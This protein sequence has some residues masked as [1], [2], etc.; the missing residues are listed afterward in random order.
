MNNTQDKLHPFS[1]TISDGYGAFQYEVGLPS[2]VA[3][4]DVV[5]AIGKKF[6]VEVPE[7]GKYVPVKD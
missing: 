3:I 4:Y 5:Q 2:D 6:N 7:E 1:I